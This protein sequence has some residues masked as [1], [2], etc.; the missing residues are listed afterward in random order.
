MILCYGA[1]AYGNLRNN[2]SKCA[3]LAGVGS[4][5]TGY[6]SVHEKTVDKTASSENDAE[7]QLKSK[8]KAG[9]ETQLV[10]WLNEDKKAG[11]WCPI[12]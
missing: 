1:I 7:Q 11:P 12:R 6:G 8:N 3:D 9:K 5:A 4:W 10:R 2:N